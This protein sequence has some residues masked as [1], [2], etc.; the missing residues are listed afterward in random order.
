MHFVSVERVFQYVHLIK[1]RFLIAR[2]IFA[3]TQI[4]IH[5]KNYYFTMLVLALFSFTQIQAQFC[6]PTGF[7]TDSNLYFI[8]DAGT[9]ACVDRPTTVS[10]GASVYTQTSCGD[11]LSVYGLTSGSALTDTSSFAADFGFS[12]CEYT[13]GNLSAEE[14]EM[15]FKTLL[16]VYPNPVK[17][18]DNLNIELG[19]NTSVKV[20]I[21]NV[22]GKRMLSTGKSDLSSVSVDVSNLENGIY[23]AQIITDMATITRKVIIMN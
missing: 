11:E 3:G 12:I 18:G 20:E 5:M 4:N 8:Y 22:T 10:I 6:P 17:S 19:V 15:I 9:S 14:F 2:Y 13:G 16:K 7:A 1:V 23:I 21:Y